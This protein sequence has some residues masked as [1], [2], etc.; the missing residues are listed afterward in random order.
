MSGQV[1]PGQAGWH[2]D[3]F[4]RYD[5]RYWDGGRWTRAV[6]RD[7]QVDTDPDQEPALE[8]PAAAGQAGHGGTLPS[9]AS[10]ATPGGDPGSG[11]SGAQPT[12]ISA[13]GW[14]AIDRFT[15]LAPEEA[16]S[17]IVQMLAI[18]GITLV[19]NSPGRIAATVTVA[20]EPNWIVVVVL[21][22]VWLVPGVVYW[23]VKSRP[24]AHP[25]AVQLLPAELGTR[26]ALQGDPVALGGI[27]PVLAQLPW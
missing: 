15:S 3:P 7:G 2:A 21:C 18:G 13:P 17:R 11:A 4:G 9:A 10:P 5:F 8:E 26:V 25:L 12:V 6:M 22:F 16:Q 20:G 24:V 23:Y 27:A 14:T 19:E 1:T